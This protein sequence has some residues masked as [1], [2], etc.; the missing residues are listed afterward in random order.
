MFLYQPE[1]SAVL[2]K[3]GG[4]NTSDLVSV[5]MTGLSR[6]VINHLHSLN[7]PFLPLV[8]LFGS[9][10]VYARESFLSRFQTI[11]VF[12]TCHLCYSHL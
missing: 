9:L 1:R 4:L 6:M 7:S 5:N 3:T 12:L 2:E 10:F 8:D 11:P